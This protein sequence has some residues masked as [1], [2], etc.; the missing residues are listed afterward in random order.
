MEYTACHSYVKTQYVMIL[1][2]LTTQLLYD[3]LCV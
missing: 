2:L 3:I 1:E